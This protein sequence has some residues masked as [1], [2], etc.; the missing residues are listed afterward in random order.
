[1][2]PDLKRRD[3]RKAFDT[4]EYQILI[5]ANKYQTGFDQPLL[6]AMY[7]DKRLADV[8]AVQTLSRLNRIS[9]GKTQTF[10]LD[11]VNKPEEIL[12]AFVPYYRTAQLSDVSDPNIIH[13]IQ[14]KL[15]AARIYTESEIEVF[16]QADFDPK[17]TQKQLQA[18]IAPAVERFRVRQKEAVQANN[19][20]ELDALA[21]FRKDLGSFVRAYEFLSQIFDYGDT[22]LEKHNVFYRHLHRG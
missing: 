16:S 1:M 20:E 18:R 21:I 4:K 9:P 11:F 15:D 12:A 5:V 17:G 2:N 7:V 19:K 14:N 22:D 6:V 3:I 13:E 10:V 8:T